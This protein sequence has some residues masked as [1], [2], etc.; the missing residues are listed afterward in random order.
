MKKKEVKTCGDCYWIHN[1][2]SKEEWLNCLLPNK[3]KMK[4]LTRRMTRK[5]DLSCHYF[6]NKKLIQ[7]L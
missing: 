5:R 1:L 4:K 3:L 6:K 7:S 2:N